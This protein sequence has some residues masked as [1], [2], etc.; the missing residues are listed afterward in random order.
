M[1][2]YY[3]TVSPLLLQTLRDL[4][5]RKEF[6]MFRLVGGTALS[7]HRGHRISV[8]IDLFTDEDYGTVNFDLI[9]EY[10]NKKYLYVDTFPFQEIGLGRSYFIGE[11]SDNC[12]KLDLY[13]TD[14]FIDDI[15][16]VDTI[17]LASVGD[18]IAMKIDVIL[19][20]GRKKDFWDINEI[21]STF[22]IH[23][24]A[25]FHRRRYPYSYDL[26]ELKKKLTDFS[27]ADADFDP[28]CLKGAHWELIKL[29]MIDLANEI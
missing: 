21:Q 27:L 16:E 22:S 25:E 12:I 23:Q 9:E 24:M 15:V 14:K 3:S 29:D 2:L 13:Y 7:L 17:R 19:R 4:M 10:F 5:S 26:V 6:S 20:K 11:N 1:K 18:I 28:V 8:D